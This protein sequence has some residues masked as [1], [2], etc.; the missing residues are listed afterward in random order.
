MNGGHHFCGRVSEKGD[1]GESVL[2]DYIFLHQ[3]TNFSHAIHK[4]DNHLFATQI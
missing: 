3:L 1:G 2:Y 4:Y